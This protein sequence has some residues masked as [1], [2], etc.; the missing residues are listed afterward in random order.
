[1]LQIVLTP[2]GASIKA[3]EPPPANGPFVVQ[4]RSPQET[5]FAANR[6]YFAARPG[7]PNVRRTPLSVGRAGHCGPE[8]G[9]DR[10]ARPRQS[11][12]RCGPPLRLASGVQPYALPL[13]HCLIP[14]VRRPLLSDPTFRRALVYGIYRQA[15]LDQ[16]LGGADMPGCVVTSSPFP[17]GVDPT[18]RWAMP[19]TRTSSPAPTSRDWRSPWQRGSEKSHR[20]RNKTEPRTSK[21]LPKLVLAYPP[22]EIAAA[23]CAV[24]PEA[25]EVD[26]YSR[27]V[28]GDRGAAARASARRRRLDVR[29]IGRPGSRWSTPGACWAKRV[30]RADAALT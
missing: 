13:V 29:R 3:G 28:A 1:M 8:A 19:R 27:R 24:H 17:V 30:W 23:A 2:H 15:I 11:L 25:V 21:K 10:R 20:K 9:R 18:T 16:M 7:Q 22:D 12:A 26:R 14:N 6:H 5:V 4:S